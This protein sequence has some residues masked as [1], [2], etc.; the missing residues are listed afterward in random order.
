MP[1]LNLCV[2]AQAPKQQMSETEFVNEALKLMSDSSANYTKAID[3]WEKATK[4]NPQQTLYSYE[5]AYCHYKLKQYDK[6]I[7]VLKKTIGK[8]PN[9]INANYYRLLGNAYDL[10]GKPD[11][12]INT[13]IQGLAKFA[14]AGELYNELGGMYYKQGNNDKAVDYWEQGVDNAP[15]H[16]SNY[17]WLAK[18]YCNSSERMW[19]VM[20]AELFIN[21][22]PNT[23]RTL[24]ISTLLANTY[25]QSLQTN[26]NRL[27]MFSKTGYKN[28]LLEDISTPDIPLFTAFEIIAQQLISKQTYTNNSL[29]AVHLFRLQFAEHWQKQNMD[30]R[31]DNLLFNWHNQLITAGHF[32][33]YNYW[34]LREGNKIQFNEWLSANKNKFGAFIQWITKQPLT[35]NA[36][37]RFGRSTSTK[38]V[39]DTK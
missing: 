33:A 35:I 16:A 19:G 3:C 27:Y 12:A 10:V 26:A 15:K 2:W 18:L 37:N 34:L 36:Q 25:Q 31:F 30:K 29:A 39:T 8:Y 28:S 23:H 32:E 38:I 22:E 20:Y 5:L 9:L 11:K 21:L 24:D 14:D 17:Y 13:Y 7:G 1:F 4:A 6:S